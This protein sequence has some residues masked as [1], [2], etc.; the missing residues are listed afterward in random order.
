MPESGGYAVCS[1]GLSV[2][3][4]FTSDCIMETH[5]PLGHGDPPRRASCQTLS[6]KT[7]TTQ[8]SEGYSVRDPGLARCQLFDGKSTVV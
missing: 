6:D 4:S 3:A 1:G 5:R 2:P 7:D 8:K